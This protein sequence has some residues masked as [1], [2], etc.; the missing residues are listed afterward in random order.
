MGTFVVTAGHS[1]TD[2]GAV[3]NGHKESDIACDMRNMIASKLR[4]LGHK[5]FTDG[6]GKENQPLSKAIKLVGNGLAIE[7]HCNAASNPAARPDFGRCEPLPAAL[8]VLVA[9]GSFL[10]FF[11]VIFKSWLC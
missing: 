8:G 10:F 2:P 6:E 5:V 7:I 11:M 3:A 9:P 4:A 1:N